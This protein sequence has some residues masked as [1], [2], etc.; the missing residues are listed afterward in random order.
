ML[1]FLS[2]RLR[3]ARGLRPNHYQSLHTTVLGPEQ[4]LIRSTIRTRGMHTLAE[5]GVVSLWQDATLEEP[6]RDAREYHSGWISSLLGISETARCP[7]EFMELT[8]L[9]LYPDE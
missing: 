7:D 6:W 4:Q 9:E 8:R 5:L 1:L 2:R 3:P